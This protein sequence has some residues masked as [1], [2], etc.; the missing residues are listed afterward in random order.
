MMPAAESDDWFTFTTSGMSLQELWLANRDLIG[1]GGPRYSTDEAYGIDEHGRAYAFDDSHENWWSDE[2]FARIPG[3]VRKLALR[4]SLVPG[5][6]NK[7]W[8]EQKALIGENE[9]VPSARDIVDGMVQY[10]RE[11]GKRIFDHVMAHTS[12]PHIAVGYYHMDIM[13]NY[14]RDG[15]RESDVGVAACREV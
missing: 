5:S 11:T 4:T 6:L 13:V 12:T 15:R 9:Q 3:Q 10:Y 7:T 1:S 14:W 2:S 8:E